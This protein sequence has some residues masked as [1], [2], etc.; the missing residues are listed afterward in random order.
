[1][2]GLYKKRAFDFVIT[3]LAAVAWGPALLICIGMIAIFDGRPIFYVST[4]RVGAHAMRIMKFRT[5]LRNAD[6]VHNREAVPISGSIRFL[7]TPRDSPLYT[8]VGRIIERFGLTEIPQVLHVL[9]GDMSLVGNRPLPENVIGALK[10]V[11]PEVE[12]RFLMPA[13]ITGPVQ[14]VG[15]SAMSDV[16]RLLIE[17]EYCLVARATQSWRLDFTILLNTVLV[18]LGWR[19]SFTVEAVSA[20][21]QRFAGPP[22]R[23]N[24]EADSTGTDASSVR[25]T[26]AVGA[27]A[28]SRVGGDEYSM[29]VVRCEVPD[30]LLIEPV[31]HRDMRGFF[32]ESYNRREMARLTGVDVEFVQ[33]N[34]S[35]SQQGVLRGLHYQVK[36]KQGKLLRVVRGAVFDVAVD[37]RQSSPTFG[38]AVGVELNETNARIFWVPPGFAHGFL[39]LSESADLLYKTTD[40]YSPEDER[41]LAWND[42]AI[43]IPWP[44]RGPPVLSSK[45]AQGVLLRDAEPL[46]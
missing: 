37:V 8:P 22:Q 11:F 35:S 18:V 44:L 19:A 3:L 5:M 24:G 20:L 1:M 28:R 13:G 38:R 27:R 31:V 41:C 43:A 29:R 12:D 9:C 33:D 14:L 30:L 32:L 21:M 7:N 34:H 26:T 40:Y 2:R 15:C 4:R 6:S 16:E 42:P 17:R 36:R 25:R 23:V 45:D 46:P 10:E 39:V